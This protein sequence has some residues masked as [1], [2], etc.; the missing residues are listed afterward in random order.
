MNGITS[1][2]LI[3]LRLIFVMGSIVAFLSI[4]ITIYYLYQSIFNENIMPGWASTIL[5]I[6][7][8]GSIQLIALGVISEYIG[9]LFLESKK[10]PNYTIEEILK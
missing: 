1:F 4:I 7:F 10:R 6:Y 3:P 5:P 8:L 9:K 2:S